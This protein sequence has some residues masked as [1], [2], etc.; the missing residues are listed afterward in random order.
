MTIIDKIGKGIKDT[1]KDIKHGIG[2]GANSVG[3][4]FSSATS[5]VTNT[6]GSAGKYG[7]DWTGDQI[8]SITGVF[9]SP[10]F[11]IVAGVVILGIIILK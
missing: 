5:S 7:L 2:S 8:S 10:T 11:L 6:I 4:W 1:G 3:N 9:S